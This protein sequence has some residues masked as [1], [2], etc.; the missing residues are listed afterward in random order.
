MPYS[1][2]MEHASHTGGLATPGNGKFM[3]LLHDK[4]SIPRV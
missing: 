3:H 1:L 4:Q 2:F